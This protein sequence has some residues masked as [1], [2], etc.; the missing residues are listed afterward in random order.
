[1]ML[2]SSCP[3]IPESIGAILT[4]MQTA[5]EVPDAIAVTGWR[6]GTLPD[7]TLP[8]T[9]RSARNVAYLDSTHSSIMWKAMPYGTENWYWINYAYQDGA[10]PP[11]GVNDGCDP[12]TY[13]CFMLLDGSIAR[14]PN[15]SIM[16]VSAWRY[17]T[18]PTI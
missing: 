10:A 8:Q 17:Y 13:A 9:P 6:T 16:D 2:L 1:M 18:C 14:V 15:A 4:L 7:A 3:P 5:R 12:A 11:A